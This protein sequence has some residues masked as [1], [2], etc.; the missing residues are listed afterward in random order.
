MVPCLYSDEIQKTDRLSLQLAQDSYEG[1]SQVPS[2]HV[3]VRL[4]THRE[5]L[6]FH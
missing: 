1:I 4:N 2:G 6:P 5:F 3:S